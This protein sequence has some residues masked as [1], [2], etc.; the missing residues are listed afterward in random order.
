M[1]LVQFSRAGTKS[2]ASSPSVTTMVPWPRAR[3]KREGSERAE[4]AA[5]WAARLGRVRVR[6]RARASG[7]SGWA[8]PEEKQPVSIF[9]FVFPFSNK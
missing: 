9:V 8:G 3:E 7:P 6:A 5:C 4:Q 2:S 1:L